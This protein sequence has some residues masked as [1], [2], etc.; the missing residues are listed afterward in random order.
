[1]KQTSQ[2]CDHE[3]YVVMATGTCKGELL[4]QWGARKSK[5]PRTVRLDLMH[6]AHVKKINGKTVK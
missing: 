5:T 4:L 6:E 2:G 1:M 3:V